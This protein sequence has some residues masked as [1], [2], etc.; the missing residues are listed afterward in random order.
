MLR[1]AL[2][3]LGMSVAMAAAVA[4]PASVALPG[5][6]AADPAVPQLT[7][8]LAGKTVFL[9]PGH[10]GSGH[11]EDLS[12]QVDDGRGGTKEC[13]TTGMTTLSGVPEHTINWQVTQL[14]KASLESIG[15]NVVLSRADDTGWGGCI[16]ERARAAN[17]SGAQVAVSIH[18]D[19]APEAD[20]GFHLIVPQLPIPNP[21]ADRAQSG[22][23]LRATNAVR[24][25][26][27]KA[28]FTPANYA[29][30]VDGLQTRVDIAGPALT[31]IPLVFVEMGNG[32]NPQD[33]AQLESPAGQL[34]HALAITTGIVGYLL[35]GEV[36]LQPTRGTPPPTLTDSRTRS[37][38]VTPRDSTRNN[39]TTTRRSPSLSEESG[40]DSGSLGTGS[41]GSGSS[42]GSLTGFAMDLLTPMLNK[43]GLGSAASLVDDE[44][45]GMAVDLAS[46]LVGIG[47]SE[48]GG[49]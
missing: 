4:V 13:Q 7:S 33:A 26:Y 31:T 20:H 40:L 2:I 19:G 12:R 35:G 22:D 25:A 28:G 30:A 37:D 46:Q 48:L 24:D 32:A 23:G 10:Q 34:K 8:Q 11:S 14:V 36:T 38:S 43:L 39:G 1:S 49:Q 18:A 17:E 41:L 9:D 29:G 5:A 16:D 6:A 21:D 42:D 44:M 3:K 27:K 47:I 15:A 45:L